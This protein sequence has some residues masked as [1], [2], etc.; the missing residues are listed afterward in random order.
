MQT[1]PRS[2][3][4]LLAP[5]KLFKL[6]PPFGGVDRATQCW[7]EPP[8]TEIYQ[9]NPPRGTNFFAVP[10]PILKANTPIWWG[11]PCRPRGEVTPQNKALLCI[12]TR[13]STFVC[14]LPLNCLSYYP[15]LVGWTLWAQ[16][17]SEPPQT[18]IYRA[19]PPQG[20]TF[21]CCPTPNYFSWYPYLVKWTLRGP[22]LK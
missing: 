7:S 2:N 17:W 10:H 13:G 5:A 18:E 12:P 11:W 21:V 19:N 22:W 6:L 8:Q 1:H 14:W 4:C 15:H 16:G 3:F 9:A 20:A